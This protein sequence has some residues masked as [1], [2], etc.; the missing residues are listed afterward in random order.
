LSQQTAH[1]CLAQF[2]PKLLKNDLS[3]HLG[4]PESKSEFQLQGVLHGDCIVNPSDGL[5]IKLR[6]TP[7]SL[8]SIQRCPSAVT[9]TSQPSIHG[10][11]VDAQCLRYKFR[12]LSV[13]YTRPKISVNKCFCSK[14]ILEMLLKSVYYLFNKKKINLRKGHFE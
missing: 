4:C 10:H 6:L 14:K 8:F 11:S 7:T 12:A 2:Y 9:V 5:G 1:R 3:D 13:L